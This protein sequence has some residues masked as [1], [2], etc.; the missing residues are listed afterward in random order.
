MHFTLQ[1]YSKMPM[2]WKMCIKITR[3]LCDVDGYDNDDDD[4]EHI[5]MIMTHYCR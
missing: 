2:A 5:E 4:D 3:Q 1:V